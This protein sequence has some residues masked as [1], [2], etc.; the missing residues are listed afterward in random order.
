MR[1]RGV[2]FRRDDGQAGVRCDVPWEPVRET[3]S[4]RE[5]GE[6][7]GLLETRDDGQGGVSCDVPWE[8]VWGRGGCLRQEMMGREGSDVMPHHM[9]LRSLSNKKY[10][11]SAKDYHNCSNGK[12]ETFPTVSLLG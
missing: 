5:C 11:W 10:I 7:G 3:R 2:A 9:V 12:E 8:R 1:G 6:E 4:G